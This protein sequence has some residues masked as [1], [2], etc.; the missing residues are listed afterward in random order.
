MPTK[1]RMTDLQEHLF[2]QLERLGD[3]SLNTEGVEREV[4]RTKAMVDVAG[5]LIDAGKLSL[6]VWDRSVQHGL[7]P[8][9][10][11]KALNASAED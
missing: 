8:K 11:P 1:S 5:T 10:L 4:L 9:R 3:E 7:V 2:A 6:D